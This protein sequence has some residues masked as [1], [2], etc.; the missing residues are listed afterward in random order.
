MNIIKPDIKSLEPNLKY[1]FILY[2]CIFK[3]FKFLI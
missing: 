2:K 3:I 1:I